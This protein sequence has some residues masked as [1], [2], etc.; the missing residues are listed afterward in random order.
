M[1][2]RAT[3]LGG[4]RKIDNIRTGIILALFSAACFVGFFVKVYFFK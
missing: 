2:E 3:V 4:N 1:G